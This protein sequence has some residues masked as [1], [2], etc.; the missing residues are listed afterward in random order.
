M[1]SSHHPEEVE[2]DEKDITYRV[3]DKKQQ[4]NVGA[5]NIK[6]LMIKL[7]KMKFNTKH[8]NIYDKSKRT[9]VMKD[10]EMVEEKEMNPKD[11]VARS[12]NNPDMFCV[13]D[14]KGKEVKLFKDKKDA[15]EYAMKNS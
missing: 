11:H 14:N 8:L 4:G 7:K 6:D 10:G 1:N 13:F 12:K 5:K 9:Q 3:S 15:E 2:L